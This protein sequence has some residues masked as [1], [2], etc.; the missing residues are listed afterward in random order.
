M[1]SSPDLVTTVAAV[2]GMVFSVW[3]LALLGAFTSRPRY[4]LW[5]MLVMWVFMFISFV[6]A[7][8]VSAPMLLPLIPEPLSTILFFASGVIIVGLFVFRKSLRLP[9]KPRPPSYN[10]H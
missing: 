7:R 6:C 9:S 8:L 1:S 4:P 2:L 5:P 10:R 3:P